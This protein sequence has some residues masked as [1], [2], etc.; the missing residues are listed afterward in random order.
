M[1]EGDFEAISQRVDHSISQVET[2]VGNLYAETGPLNA[3]KE[4]RENPDLQKAV[5]NII[6]ACVSSAINKADRTGDTKSLDRIAS[7]PRF[8]YRCLALAKADAKNVPEGAL[9][10]GASPVG[11]QPP[12]PPRGDGLNEEDRA[13]LA[14]ARADGVNLTAADIKKA[15]E[16]TN[17]S[18]Y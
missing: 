7:D 4:F 6:G 5:E 18:V 14:A 11:Q 16:L 12:A 2:T 17:K 8:P 1:K 15:R 9:R 10:P 3:D 13:A